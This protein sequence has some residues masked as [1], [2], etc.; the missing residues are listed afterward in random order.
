MVET[1]LA[2]IPLL[3]LFL[4]IVQYTLLAAAQLVVQHAAVAGARSASVVLDDD[5]ARYEDVERL[6]IDNGG[7]RDDGASR[8]LLAVGDALL[9]AVPEVPSVAG[10]AAAIQGYGPR[11]ALVRNAVYAKLAA[12]VPAR[13][14]AAFAGAPG[15]S[16]LD[17]L[18]RSPALRLA[19]APLY[20]PI[21]TAITFPRAPRSSSVFEDRVD[22]TELLTIRVTHITTCT[23]PLV[24]RLMCRSLEDL[25]GGEHAAEL[26]R[27]P[28]AALQETLVEH[29]MR[30]V[31]LQ[32]EASMPLQDAPYRYASQREASP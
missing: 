26:S 3:T 11:M 32:A 30:A 22:A 17:A 5:P 29:G 16:V 8:D 10:L 27:A 7:A 25:R 20:L 12:I 31:I 15:S 24:A 2:F 28:G 18:G 6:V 4:G 1:L 9:N 14:L 13:A 23:I 21:T 19:Q